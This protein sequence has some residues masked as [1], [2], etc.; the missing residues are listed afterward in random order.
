MLS[1][2][3]TFFFKLSLDLF[4]FLSATL[5]LHSDWLWCDSNITWL[6]FRALEKCTKLPEISW[7]KHLIHTSAFMFPTAIVPRSSHIFQKSGN[8]LPTIISQFVW[9]TRKS[10]ICDLHQCLLSMLWILTLP[11]CC[12]SNIYNIYPPA[13]WSPWLCLAEC[14]AF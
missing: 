11:S 5:A 13:S 10:P 6:S 3:Y 2:C 12:S 8:I 1:F 9:F 7:V 4:F 14:L